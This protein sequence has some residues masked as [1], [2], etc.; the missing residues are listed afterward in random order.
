MEEGILD[1]GV[2]YEGLQITSESRMYLAETAK[3]AKFLAIVGFVFL[4]IMVLF[5]LFFS[6]IMGGMMAGFGDEAS[7]G[8]INAMG[9]FM[10][11]MY[12]VI[13]LIYFFPCYYLLK[14]ANQTKAALANNDTHTLTDAFKNHKSVYKFMGIFM[15]IILGFYALGFLVAIVGGAAT[16]F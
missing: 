14:F 3:W 9:G 13:A 16:A 6:T 1:D 7:A 2:Q 4:G 15:I 8:A 12:V 10:G 11:I 5:G